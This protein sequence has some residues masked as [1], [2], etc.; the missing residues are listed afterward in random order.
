MFHLY[1]GA[2]DLMLYAGSFTLA[3]V[4]AKALTKEKTPIRAVEWDSED[5]L[6]TLAL[7]PATSDIDLSQMM[8]TEE[9]NP[10]ELILEV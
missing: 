10:H 3:L 2:F 5:I 1:F 6:A 4:F 8:E 7:R 9:A